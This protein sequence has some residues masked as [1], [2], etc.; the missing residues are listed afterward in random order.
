M[1]NI[2]I[3]RLLLGGTALAFIPSALA[4]GQSY[5]TKCEDIY[6]PFPTV[7]YAKCKDSAGNK[8]LTGLY[9]AF[10]AVE[11][12]IIV[13]NDGQ[14]ACSQLKNFSDLLSQTN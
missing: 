1:I 11:G 5:K 10:C 8:H 4:T 9:T 7:L 12:D 3:K 6:F 13:K 14:L 2:I